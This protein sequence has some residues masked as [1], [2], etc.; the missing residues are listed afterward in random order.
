M[1]T[2]MEGRDAS[3]GKGPFSLH[4]DEMPRTSTERN[5]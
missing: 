3:C 5:D 2:E 1:K 4:L